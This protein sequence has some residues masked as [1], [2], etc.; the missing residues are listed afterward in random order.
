MRDFMLLVRKDVRCLL[1]AN[2]LVL[3]TFG[4]SLLL[5]LVA[6]FAFRQIG[7]GERELLEVTPGIVWLV[8]L[9][10][11]VI[12]LNH[13]FA[14]EQEN[15]ALFGLLL[16][17]VEP[18]TVYLAKL[19]VNAVFLGMIQCFVLVAHG[20]LFGANFWG[21]FFELL[22]VSLL[23]G[24]GFVATGTLLSAIAVCTKGRDILLPL[25]LFPLCIP[26]V[27]AA[28]FL[29]RGLLETG[30]LEVESFWFSLLCGFPM[31]SVVLS[32]ALFE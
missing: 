15:D 30:G 28:V 8:F 32:W 27:A 23:G 10:S 22:G 29:S 14:L 12:A 13:S 9:F 31:L 18:S 6:S 24:I 16:T 2:G 11:G 1:R 3:S 25:M 7:Y 5:T 26:L 21:V 20:V 17:S 19:A 4:F